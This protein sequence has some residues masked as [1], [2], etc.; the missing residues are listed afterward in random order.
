MMFLRKMFCC[1]RLLKTSVILNFNRLAS[2]K[3][4]ALGSSENEIIEKWK[5]KFANENISE[6]E[7]SIKHIMDH[8][9]EMVRI[10]K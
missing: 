9:T 2:S 7:S 4:I 8:V 5:K 6:I 3:N 1:K 10:I